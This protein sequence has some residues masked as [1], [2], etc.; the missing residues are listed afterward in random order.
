MKAKII[1]GIVLIFL[2]FALT[3][4]GNVWFTRTA[5][6]HE[7]SALN[8]LTATPVV[9]PTNP[10]ANPSRVSTYNFYVALVRWKNADGC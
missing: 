1:A 4:A 5:I 2:G 9:Y 10:K 8:D 3:F 6:Q 7:C